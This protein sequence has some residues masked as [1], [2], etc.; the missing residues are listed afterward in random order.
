[1]EVW[2]VKVFFLGPYDSRLMVANL[3]ETLS[4][5]EL[6]CVLVCIYMLFKLGL[7]TLLI[8]LYFLY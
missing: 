1:M 2:I 3:D 7:I 6:L 4:F 5:V 8:F